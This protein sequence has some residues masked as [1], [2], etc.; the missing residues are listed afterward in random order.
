MTPAAPELARRIADAFEAERIPYAIGGAPALAAWGFQRATND[1]DIDLF[2]APDEL[3]E[4]FTVLERLGC[5]LDG[6]A[7]TESARE[8]GDFRARFARMRID[9]FVPSIPFYRSAQDRI[10][11]RRDRRRG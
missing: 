9:F 10:R 4:V 6:R 7:C 8:R 11:R 3:G 5:E 2:V 1:V